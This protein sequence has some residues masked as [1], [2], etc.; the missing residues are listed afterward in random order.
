MIFYI[1]VLIPVCED[2]SIRL[3]GGN[4]TAGRVEVCY[5]DIWGTV[6]DDRWDVNDARVVCRQLGLH[7]Q[8]KSY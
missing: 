6:C 1:T 7:S 5:N 2:S 4:D 8:S 3:V